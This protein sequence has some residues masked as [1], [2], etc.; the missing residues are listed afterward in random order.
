MTSILCVCAV[1][2][3]FMRY[4]VIVGIPLLAIWGGNLLGGGGSALQPEIRLKSCPTKPKIAFANFNH[5]TEATND[6]GLLSNGNTP[7]L[8]KR[9]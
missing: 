5:F 8:K 9:T 1:H 6:P 2:V 3:L 4:D 7:F